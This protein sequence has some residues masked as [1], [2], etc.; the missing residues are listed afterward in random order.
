MACC[1]N[2]FYSTEYLTPNCLIECLSSATPGATFVNANGEVFTLIAEDPCNL[3]NWVSASSACIEFTNLTD[4]ITVC[5]NEQIEINGSNGIL[6]DLSIDN[7]IILVGN[8]LFGVV[9]PTATPVN[10][11]ELNYYYNTV[12][13]EFYIWNPTGALW[14]KVIYTP[15][16]VEI[17]SSAFINPLTPLDSEVVSW[18]T[19]NGPFNTGT[20]LYLIGTG[21]ALSPDFV[22]HYTV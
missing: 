7:K 4:S 21:S 11:T 19:A 5:E 16:K 22:W 3:A 2:T 9:A 12:T 1:L 18:V 10:D 13:K 20:I 15:T 6:V 8:S 17:P 14:E